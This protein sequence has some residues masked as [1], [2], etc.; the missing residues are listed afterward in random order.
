MSKSAPVISMS[1]LIQY[2]SFLIRIWRYTDQAPGGNPRAWQGEVEHI[3]SSRGWTFDSLESL[4]AFL[5]QQVE[6]A[7]TLALTEEEG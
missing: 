5:Q 2:T 1:P 7:E 6:R 4:L 3:Q